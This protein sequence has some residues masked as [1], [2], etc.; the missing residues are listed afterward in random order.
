M[1]RQLTIFSLP[2]LL[3]TGLLLTSGTA[4]FDLCSTYCTC[5]NH[6][7]NCE[8]GYT[9]DSLSLR[10]LPSN[11]SSIR[12][13]NFVIRRI[14]TQHF[15]Q[16]TRLKYLE[17]TDC[18]TIL[19][20]GDSFRQLL[21]LERINLQ[22]NHIANLSSDL[23][24]TLPNLTYLHL[25][26]NLIERLPESLF[27]NSTQLE[28]LLLTNNRLRLLPVRIF[29]S[30]VNLKHLDLSHN[31]ISHILPRTFSFISLVRYIDLSDN[32]LV[33]IHPDLFESNNITVETKLSV[34]ANPFNCNC[35]LAWLQD[36]LAGAVPHLE[37]INSSSV[38]CAKPRIYH[39]RK[40]DGEV[41][42]E[43]L[44]CTAPTVKVDV[45]SGHMFHNNKV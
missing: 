9:M 13:H 38:V 40:L 7:L 14:S 42:L 39:G 21:L 41:E 24:T 16:F 1:E 29:D 17:V 32:L 34:S 31:E 11:L 44:N 45:K 19:V 4:R 2:L 33:T 43:H 15:K 37:M 27:Q 10:L 28:T 30:L 12:V 20:D 8:N 6:T 22:H 36:A 5:G 25:G 23:F 26:Y 35:G 18:R 3:L